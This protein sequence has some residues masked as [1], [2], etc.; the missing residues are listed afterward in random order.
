MY[1]CSK[2]IGGIKMGRL[3]SDIFKQWKRSVNKDLSS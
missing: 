2:T 1:S 3:I